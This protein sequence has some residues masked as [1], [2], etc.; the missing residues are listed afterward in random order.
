MTLPRLPSSAAVLLASA[1]SRSQIATVA[2]ESRNRSTMARPMPCAPPVTTA[3][4]PERSIALVMDGKLAK[5]RPLDHCNIV[6][7]LPRQRAFVPAAQHQIGQRRQHEEDDH[8][9]QRQQQQR[10]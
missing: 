10:G 5:P 6:L 4:R 2:L 8:A 7:A 3:L 1:V 9:R